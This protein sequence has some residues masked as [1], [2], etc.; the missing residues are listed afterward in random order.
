MD[1][2]QPAVQRMHL[3]VGEKIGYGL[4][5]TAA[6]LVW[7]TLIFFLPI[8]YTDVF[9]LS[10]AA[11]G[12]L[13]LVC[14]I[15][16]GVTDFF[17]GVVA[18]RTDTR[19]G[20]FRPWILWTALPFGILTV[21]TFTTPDLSYNGKLIYA[22]VTY[23]A[24]IL[25][26]TANNIPYSALTGVITPDP[27][28]RTSVS[29]YRFVFAFLGG[30]ITQGLNIYLVEFF[31]QGDEIKGYKW[32]MALFAVVSVILF[33]ITFATTRER[34]KPSRIERSSIKRDAL[35]LL[36]NKPWLILFFVGILFVTFTTFRGGVTL[37]YFKYYINNTEIAA[38]FMVV[39]LLASM[40]GAGITGPLTARFGKRAVMNVCILIGIISSAWLY[41]IGPGGIT[42]IFVLSAITEFSTGPIVALFFAMLAD[43]ADY[44][45]WKTQRRATALVFSAGTLSI[46]FGTAVAASIS[47][48]MLAWFGYVANVEQTTE[49]LLGIRLLFS[50]IPAGVGVLLLIVFQFYKLDETL[51]LQIEAELN[52]RAG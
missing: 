46:K 15:G 37:Y 39:G 45:E 8:F 25:V 24:L 29:S 17:M 28:E 16:D 14:R 38:V 47:G 1:G 19:W 33:I 23:T 2:A 48:W 20:K 30:L 9:G 27:I 4:G 5:D 22:Y 51:L 40:L 26:F 32:T 7:R 12:T 34:V 10:A 31:G 42:M 13:M 49:A 44:S 52:E 41:L 35:D 36:N 11:V 3:S 6:N 21:L 18:D 43:A 50:L